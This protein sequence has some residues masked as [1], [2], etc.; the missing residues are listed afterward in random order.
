MVRSFRA[1]SSPMILRCIDMA[2]YSVHLQDIS[3][4]CSTIVHDQYF[5]Q[6]RYRFSCS[7]LF[8]QFLDLGLQL[9]PLQIEHNVCNECTV[10]Y[11]LKQVVQYFYLLPLFYCRCIEKHLSHNPSQD[12]EVRTL[13][14]GHK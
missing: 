5:S 8:G 4:L 14:L 6:Y 13:L 11:Q 7:H 12:P 3:Q 2:Y 9:F 1:G 10:S